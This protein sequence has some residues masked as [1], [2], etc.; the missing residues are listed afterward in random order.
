[1][2]NIPDSPPPVA[3]TAFRAPQARLNG[4][5]IA[6]ERAAAVKEFVRTFWPLAAVAA[7]TLILALTYDKALPNVSVTLEQADAWAAM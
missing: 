4:Q 5:R 2:L 1:M 6:R 3:V 7:L